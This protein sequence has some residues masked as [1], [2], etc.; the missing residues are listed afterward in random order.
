[1]VL[2]IKEK[3]EFCLGNIRQD[4]EICQRK[5]D[6]IDH[7]VEV[8]WDTEKGADTDLESC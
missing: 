3:V 5:E 7:E 4:Y 1:M 8:I 6:S 2:C